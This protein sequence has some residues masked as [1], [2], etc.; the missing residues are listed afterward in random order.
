MSIWFFFGGE[1]IWIILFIVAIMIGKEISDFLVTSITIFFY[2]FAIKNIVL[3]TYGFL[4]CKIGR[5]F[6]PLYVILDTVRILIFFSFFSLY[7]RQYV[8]ASGISWIGEIFNFIISVILLGS[9]YLTGEMAT[10]WHITGKCVA[11]KIRAFFL[12]LFFIIVLIGLSWF[13]VS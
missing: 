1:I 10:V 5:L 11:D 4:K 6:I 2:V 7:A 8:E 3:E 12:D 13:S 9:I